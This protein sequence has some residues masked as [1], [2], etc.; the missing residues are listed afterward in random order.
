MEGRQEKGGHEYVRVNHA[1]HYCN[2]RSDRQN[3]WPSDRMVVGVGW[4]K[5]DGLESC[6]GGATERTC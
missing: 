3:P 1:G 4:R 2:S 5:G 6:L